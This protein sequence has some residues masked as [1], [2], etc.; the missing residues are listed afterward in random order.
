M[1]TKSK[2]AQGPKDGTQS[3]KPTSRP[4]TCSAYFDAY[5]I[6]EAGCKRL[7]RHKGEHRATLHVTKAAKPTAKAKRTARRPKA[8]VTKA[9]QSLKALKDL[10]TSLLQ[11]VEDGNVTAS[12]ALSSYAAAESAYRREAKRRA[13]LRAMAKA[14]KVV[15]S[16]PV[17]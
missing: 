5:G 4:K 16:E 9:P 12:D 3:T 14:A 6:G 1:A 2:T 10:R 17:A 11:A 7:P 13:A 8:D 15:T